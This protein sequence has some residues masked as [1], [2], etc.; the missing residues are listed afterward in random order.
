LAGTTLSKRRGTGPIAAKYGMA[1][2]CEQSH[3]INIAKAM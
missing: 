3:A 2:A 1:P